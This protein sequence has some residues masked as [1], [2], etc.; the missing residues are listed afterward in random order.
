MSKAMNK[1][2]AL[3]GMMVGLSGGLP[4]GYETSKTY[5]E[6][7]EK[8]DAGRFVVKYKGAGKG[9]FQVGYIGIPRLKQDATIFTSFQTAKAIA[10]GFGGKVVKLTK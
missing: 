7:K 4:Y 3:T 1:L 6:P 5:K 2:A 10:N 9:Y 8:S